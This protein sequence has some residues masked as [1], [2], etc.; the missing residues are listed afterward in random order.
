MLADGIWDQKINTS[1]PGGTLIQIRPPPAGPPTRRTAARWTATA[2]LRSGMARESAAGSIYFLFFFIS[3]SG[4]RGGAHGR[5]GPRKRVR[6]GGEQNPPF[7]RRAVGRRGGWRGAAHER[8]R[9][10]GWQSIHSRREPAQPPAQPQTPQ[11]RRQYDEGA[12][13]PRAHRTAAAGVRGRGRRGASRAA[14]HTYRG[15]SDSERP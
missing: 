2:L 4:A 3:S 13:A 1:T 7:G 12:S 10:L 8:T 5:V 11:W 14:A 9:A 15:R 6:G